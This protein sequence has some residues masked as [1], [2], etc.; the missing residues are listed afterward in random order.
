MGQ[1][2]KQQVTAAPFDKNLGFAPMLSELEAVEKKEEGKK[3]EKKAESKEAMPSIKED[4]EEG[5]TT[6]AAPKKKAATTKKGA[7][8]PAQKAV[9]RINGLTPIQRR[10]LKTM[11]EKRHVELLHSLRL[12]ET[13][14]DATPQDRIVEEYE[15][16]AAHQTQA[17]S[18]RVRD[19]EAKLLKMINRALGKFDVDEFGLCEGTE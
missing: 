18:L 13:A 6:E 15:Q 19:K 17:V 3:E 7:K 16:A 10:E 4:A 14:K 8:K 1:A 11:L 9:K 2:K 5:Y 12:D